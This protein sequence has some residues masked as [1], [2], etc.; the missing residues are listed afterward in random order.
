MTFGESWEDALRIGGRIVGTEIRD[1]I[2]TVW[3]DLERRSDAQKVDSALKLRSMGLPLPFL[4]ERIGLTPQ[5]SERVMDALE[6]EQ[7]QAAA[8]SAASFGL[9]TGQSPLDEDA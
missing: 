8:V 1:D 7:Q 6:S 5:A 9:A 2:E 3:A 4:L